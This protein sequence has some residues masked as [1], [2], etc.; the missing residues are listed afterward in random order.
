[1]RNIYEEEHDEDG[2]TISGAKSTMRSSVQPGRDRDQDV[3]SLGVNG[4]VSERTTLGNGDVTMKDDSEPLDLDDLMEEMQQPIN[5]QSNDQLKR[6][7]MHHFTL[8]PRDVVSIYTFEGRNGVHQLYL[9]LLNYLA[10]FAGKR[11]SGVTPGGN[12]RIFAPRPF[13]DCLYKQ[14]SMTYKGVVAETSAKRGSEKAEHFTLKFCGVLFPQTI[15]RV[16]SLAKAILRQ[17]SS[18]GVLDQAVLSFKS[19]DSSHPLS[20]KQIVRQAVLSREEDP[21]RVRIE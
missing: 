12:T 18:E 10:G 1:M 8:N 15:A 13:L 3:R 14:C 5:F 2:E 20:H 17:P 16:C 19:D 11:S 6:S 7:S 4:P 9:L 21:L